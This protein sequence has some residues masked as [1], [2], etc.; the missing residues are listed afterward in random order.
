M[1]HKVKQSDNNTIMKKYYCIPTTS[2][3]DLSTIRTL[4]M[5]SWS[6][7]V[8]PTPAP[9]RKGPAVGTLYI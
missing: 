4:M 5:G 8:E 3:M 7:Q 1:M 6:S 9:A 2:V